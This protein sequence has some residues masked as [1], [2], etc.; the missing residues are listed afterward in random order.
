MSSAIRVDFG[1]SLIKGTHRYPASPPPCPPRAA[2]PP[3]CGAIGWV[4][5]PHRDL[6]APSWQPFE[7]PQ[8]PRAQ[9]EMVL[10]CCG[11]LGKEEPSPVGTTSWHRCRGGLLVCFH[12]G[13]L[14]TSTGAHAP[15]GVCAHI[16]DLQQPQVGTHS[17]RGGGHSCPQPAPAAH[18]HR[19]C[20]KAKGEPCSRSA[21]PPKRGSARRRRV[22]QRPPRAPRPPLQ[23]PP[24]QPPGLWYALPA[25]STRGYL[26]GRGA[27]PGGSVW[28]GAGVAQ[29]GARRWA[30]PE[31]EGE[32]QAA[33]RRV[34]RWGWGWGWG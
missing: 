14:G 23:P 11:F 10:S 33:P 25:I 5:A 22:H 32:W 21:S 16:R 20:V 6:M 17:P 19:R 1:N 29:S 26:M 30:S 18:R 24:R 34:R 9:G 13:A 8:G 3:P 31:A 4:P 2:G 12:L 27:G 15:H 28:A 7:T